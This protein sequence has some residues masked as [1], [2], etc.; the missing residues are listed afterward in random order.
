MGDAPKNLGFCTN[1]GA[2]RGAGGAEA[3]QK[4]GIG[5]A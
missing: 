1:T 4:S 2:N 3:A 5:F